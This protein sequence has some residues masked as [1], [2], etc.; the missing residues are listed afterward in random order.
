[1]TILDN[2]RGPKRG[3]EKKGTA[4]AFPLCLLLI[5][6]GCAGSMGTMRPGPSVPSNQAEITAP[7]PTQQEV[8]PQPKR[9]APQPSTPGSPQY[10][11][12]TK[13]PRSPVTHGS[14][15]PP[16]SNQPGLAKLPPPSLPPSINA[17]P[18]TANSAGQVYWT[19]GGPAVTSGGTSR[20]Q[21][22]VTPGG[23]SAVI[24]PGN[25]VSTLLQSNGLI[26]AVPTPR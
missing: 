15:T 21:T 3:P 13:P 12:P 26:Q 20:Y 18:P 10:E 25:G 24:V 2:A 22:S 4:S 23:G 17:S 19:P 7:A 1:M 14:S 11:R 16:G 8:I 9:A 5:L 6:S